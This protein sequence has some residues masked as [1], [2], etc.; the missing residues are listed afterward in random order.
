MELFQKVSEASA[1]LK[2]KGFV[3]AQLGLVLGTGLGKLVEELKEVVCEEYEA[4]PH[5]PTSTV[6]FHSG[7]LFIG[8]LNGKRVIVMQGRLHYY[9]GYEMEEVAFPIRVMKALGVDTLLLSGAAGSMNLAWQKGDLMLLSDHINL[10]PSN[11]LIGKNDPRF[12][13]RFPDMSEAYDHE[14][15]ETFKRC[16]DAMEI[17]LRQGVYASLPG[18][19][20]ESPSEYRFLRTIGA[21]AVGMSTVPEVIVAKH[22]GM[23]CAAVIV[24]TDE[25]DP[26]DLK[27]IDIPE[28]IRVANAAEKTLIK[29]LKS[30]LLLV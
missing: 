4:M 20:L 28:I 7:K 19:M 5:F 10:L 8:S 6:E 18:P 1:Y 26:D 11:P 16:A 23:R 22:S 9:E 24:L 12:G 25:C 30:A 13:P 29:L 3:G 27:P 2:T 14:L 21:D 17:S 15:Q